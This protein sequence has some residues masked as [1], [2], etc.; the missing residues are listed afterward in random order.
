MRIRL[1]RPYQ[2]TPA[3]V[4]LNNVPAGRAKQMI[5]N[6]IAVYV[7]DKKKKKEDKP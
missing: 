2:I 6:G 4:V 5:K 3:G 1:V 7:E